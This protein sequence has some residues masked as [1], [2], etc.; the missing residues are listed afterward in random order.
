MKHLVYFYRNAAITK[1]QDG[2][3]IDCGYDFNIYKTLDDAKNA[4]DKH[5][6][7]FAWNRYGTIPRRSDKPIKIIGKFEG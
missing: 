7:G 6:G 3:M 5:L 4:I 2:W 1:Y